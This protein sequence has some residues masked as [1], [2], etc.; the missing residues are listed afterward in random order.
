MHAEKCLLRLPCLK[1]HGLMAS[2][3][4]RAVPYGAVR[5]RNSAKDLPVFLKQSDPLPDWQPMVAHH[6]FPAR[7]YWAPGA[8][9][10]PIFMPA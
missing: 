9:L 10:V 6:T 5:S 8:S 4:C 2:L 3:K 7:A 1:L